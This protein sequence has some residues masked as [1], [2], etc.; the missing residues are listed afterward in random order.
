[1]TLQTDQNV[2]PLT[3][4]VP[5]FL[6]SWMIGWLSEFNISLELRSGLLSRQVLRQQKKLLYHIQV[7]GY[8]T[9]SQ[10]LTTLS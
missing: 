1:M 5:T 9:R 2:S 10:N 3:I 7:S 4:K 6:I 8:I